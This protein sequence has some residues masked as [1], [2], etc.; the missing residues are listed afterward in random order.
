MTAAGAGALQS[1]RTPRS[2]KAA[3][4]RLP[5]AGRM[6]LLQLIEA[7]SCHYHISSPA[8]SPPFVTLMGIIILITGSAINA[9]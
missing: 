7:D 4:P 5:L 9:Y 3:A 1:P 6:L 8:L 2:E